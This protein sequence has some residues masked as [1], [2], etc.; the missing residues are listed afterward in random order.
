MAFVLRRGLSNGHK[1]LATVGLAVLIA[2]SAAV[3][4]GDAA[5]G[6]MLDVRDA[7]LSDVVLLLTQQSGVNVVVSPDVAGKTVTAQL[8]D[9][10]L[11]E[12]LAD[13]VQS[14]GVDCWKNEHGT[15][16]IGG[17]RPAQP[18]SSASVE[19][20]RLPAQPEQVRETPRVI[21][22]CVKLSN[23]DAR[24]I[25]VTLGVLPESQAPSLRNLLNP[26]PLS[27][28]KPIGL[29]D[30]DR[31]QVGIAIPGMSREH[32]ILG[33]MR[34]TVPPAI[35]PGARPTSEGAGR[36]AT[37]D[38]GAGQYP[39]GRVT[40]PSGVGGPGVPGGGRVPPGGGT[41][42]TAPTNLMPEGVYLVQPF[43]PDNS[44]IVQGTEEG[45]NEF[46]ELV[47]MLDVPPKQV[48]IKAEFIEVSTNDVKRLGID[49]SLE[50]LNETINTNFNPAGNVLVGFTTGN[51]VASLRT[52]LT[53]SSGKIIN[54]PII[55]T[56]NNELAEISI[57]SVIPYWTTVLTP[58]GIGAGYTVN[59]VVNSINVSTYLRVQPRV[60][61][62]NTI[63]LALAPNVSDTGRMFESPDG[64]TTIPE[65]RYQS[66]IT[67]RRV[68]NGETIVLGGF[69]RADESVNVTE[70]P[71][72][73]RLPIIGP[74]FR[75]ASRSSQ[76]R[77][78][79][80]FVTPTIIGE[81]AA[82]SAIG[83]ATP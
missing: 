73:G 26:G 17:K 71:I 61:A 58:N 1:R 33:G 18:V 25:L 56:M 66:L 44:I 48:Q 11:E 65:T 28:T 50:R 63:T 51:L 78:L 41:T 34:D 20:P 36:A 31:M 53:Q 32:E 82:G 59:T 72:L 35:D 10:P 16:V 75:S 67:R 52:E 81:K 39:P 22:E 37:N 23:S 77:E 83:V 68:M 54:S 29:I 43:P 76:D 3:S 6:V 14:A 4:L 49:W 15:F 13:V 21:R 24:E 40:G 55:S 60:N 19:P 64:K 38:I 70:V 30:E 12:A 74:L 69:I 7:R 2:C 42:G 5:R 80:I 27:L 46:K 62:D 79:L 45:I 8:H 9:L 57:G 47:H